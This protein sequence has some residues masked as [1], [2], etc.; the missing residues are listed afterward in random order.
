MP[1]QRTDVP[2]QAGLRHDVSR[3]VHSPRRPLSGG[4]HGTENAALRETDTAPRHDCG[5]DAAARPISLGPPS[6]VS[7]IVALIGEICDVHLPSWHSWQVSGPAS[8]GAPQPARNRSPLLLQQR[9]RRQRRLLNRARSKRSGNS[10][11]ARNQIQLGRDPSF[12]LHL[13]P[14]SLDLECVRQTKRT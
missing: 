12:S 5:Q 13:L 1:G 4:L 6:V 10:L 8:P 11:G 9:A 14:V 3:G 7:S 2:S